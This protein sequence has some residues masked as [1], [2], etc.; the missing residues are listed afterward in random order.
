MRGWRGLAAT[1]LV[2]GLLLSPG[3]AEGT[4]VGVLREMFRRPVTEWK[5]TLRAHSHLLDGEFF[6][7]VDRRIQWGLDNGHV[8]DAFRFAMVGDFAAEAVGRP[9]SYRVDLAQGFFDV[10]ED[11]LASQVVEDVLQTSAGSRSAIRAQFLRGQIRARLQ[12]LDGAYQDFRTLADMGYRPE[13][14]W[15]QCGLISSFVGR[16]ERARVEFEKAG[17]QEPEPARELIIPPGWVRAG[18][19][20]PADLGLRHYDDYESAPD[21][22]PGSPDLYSESQPKVRVE[23]LDVLLQLAAASYDLTD[24]VACGVYGSLLYRVGALSQASSV[25]DAAISGHPESV[26]LLRGR[27]NT[28][29]RLYDQTGQ[30]SRLMAAL[31]DYRRAAQLAPEH[32]LLRWELARAEAKL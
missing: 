25:Y 18:P 20:R 16:E 13:E 1:G 3:R 32:E 12:D 10:Q 4:A 8:D 24:P 9:Q 7:S 31:A 21:V 28:L 14:T 29:E 17:R 6:A 26:D 27:G 23:N 30:R 2:L 15:Y 19:Y 22:C 11:Q 5:G